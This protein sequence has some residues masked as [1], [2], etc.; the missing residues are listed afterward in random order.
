MARLAPVPRFDMTFEVHR[1]TQTR[2]QYV[3]FSKLSPHE[4]AGKSQITVMGQNTHANNKN[5]DAVV[6]PDTHHESL[7]ANPEL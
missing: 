7:S 2:G 5:D 3:G 4:H 1:E 6:R